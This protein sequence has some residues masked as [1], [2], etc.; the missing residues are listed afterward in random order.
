MP[1]LTSEFRPNWASAPGDTIIDILDERGWSVGEFAKRI[2]QTLERTNGLL[3]GRATITIRMAQD[4]AQ[5]LG[6]SVEFW[7][8]RDAQFREDMARV[9]AADQEWLGELPLG[10]MIRLGWLHPPP[11]PSEEVEACLRFFGAASIAAWRHAY[12]ALRAEVAFRTSPT[13]DSRPGAVAAWLRQGELLCSNMEC[14]PWDPERFRE[15]L[16]DARRLT[17]AKDPNHFL[18]RL[19]QLCAASGV[20]VAVVRAPTGCRASGATRFVSPK[21]ALLLLSFRYLSDDQ[22]WF[23][24][25]HEAGHLLLHGQEILFLEGLDNQSA[26]QE[27]EANDF[28]EHVLI[29]AEFRDEFW[30]L[31]TEIR[32]IVRFANHVGVAAGIVVGQ[33]QHYDRIPRSHFNGL[34]RRFQWS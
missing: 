27:R 12:E 18:P 2:G 20:A 15:A 4:L 29:P 17:F 6:A 30:A 25:F 16:S 31:P 14:A 21:K 19:R 32:A 24:F 13:L 34:K 33:L 10:D 1:T 23:T 5:V 26:S 3:Q 8:A 28:A 11:R 22:F 7:M 9:H